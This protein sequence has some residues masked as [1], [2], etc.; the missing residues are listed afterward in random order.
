MLT[1][2]KEAHP[3]FILPYTS[4][5]T[6]NYNRPEG[7][8]NQKVDNKSHGRN[9][10]LICRIRNLAG[11]PL[12]FER[13][14]G[15]GF[16]MSFHYPLTPLKSQNKGSNTTPNGVTSDITDDSDLLSHV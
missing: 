4:K 13:G 2:Y 7:H 6:A 12:S 11:K 1:E 16:N 15:G 3:N 10:N 14:E 5:W 8:S 9:I